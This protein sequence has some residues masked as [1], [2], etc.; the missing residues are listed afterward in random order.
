[1][2]VRNFNELTLSDEQI[3]KLLIYVIDFEELKEENK[4]LSIDDYIKENVPT[5]ISENGELLKG[6]KTLL[7]DAD[8]FH[9]KYPRKLKGKELLWKN[10]YVLAKK[11]EIEDILAQEKSKFDI[12]LGSYDISYDISLELFNKKLFKEKVLGD[13]HKWKITLKD[14]VSEAGIFGYDE[15]TREP[16]FVGSK[17]KHVIE[18]GNYSSF[19]GIAY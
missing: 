17:F 13:I 10:I 3:E 14:L 19:A 1:M 12:N 2:E 5:K 15:E 18:S 6:L 11:E 9:F 16:I 4:N 7:N 8:Y